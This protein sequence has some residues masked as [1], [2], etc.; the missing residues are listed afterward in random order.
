MDAVSSTIESVRPREERAARVVRRGVRRALPRR[1][2]RDAAPARRGGVAIAVVLVAAVVSPP[3]RAFVDRVRAG[4]RR[5]PRRPPLFTLPAP[6][7]ILVAAGRRRRLGHAR[8]RLAA[9]ARRLQRRLVVAVRPLRRRHPPERA[10]RARHRGHRPLDARATRAS[11]FPRWTGSDD[12]HA[13]R[14][15]R[16]RPAPRR[17]RRRHGRPAAGDAPRPEFRPPGARRRLQPRL[18]HAG[19]RRSSLST[20]H[21]RRAVAARPRE[22]PQSLAWSSDG[23]LLAAAAPRRVVVLSATGAV[24]RGVSTL[25]GTITG[26][27]FE[28]GTHRLALTIRRLPAVGQGRRRRPPRRGAAPLRR[29]RDVPRHRLVSE[30][31]VAARRLADGEP[32]GVPAR[33][34]RPRRREHP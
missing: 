13:H 17:R 2:A 5:R 22:A 10:R 8:R 7:R 11:R 20:R 28:P 1:T 21:R 12:R 31:A 34:A 19:R 29:P 14:L 9:A 27:A 16:R 25:S 18:R 23:T 3:G 24:A 15:P 4:G 26:A 33:R 6:G 30:R 32:V